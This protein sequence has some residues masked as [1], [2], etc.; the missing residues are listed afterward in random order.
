MN[1]SLCNLPYSGDNPVVFM[2]LKIHKEVIGR[3]FIRLFRDIFPAGVENFVRIAEGRSY[4]TE[5]KGVG[6]YKYIKEVRRTYEGAKFFNNLFN[7]Y[8][9]S[10]DIYS[11][12]GTNAGT[13]Y[14][15]HPIPP[16]YKD[17]YYPHEVKGMVSLVPFR[18]ETA[19]GCNRL[20]YDST[21]MILLNDIKPFNADVYHNL[22]KDQIV[23]GHVY[24]GTELLDKIN[25]LLQPFAGR[26][27]PDIRVGKCGIF[28]KTQPF[29]RTRPITL[30]DRKKMTVPCVNRVC[31]EACYK[32]SGQEAE[33]LGERC[34]PCEK[35][36]IDV[37]KCKELIKEA[38]RRQ[39]ELGAS[40]EIYAPDSREEFCPSQNCHEY[41]HPVNPNV[42]HE[43][44]NYVTTF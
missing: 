17:F 42:A 7:N 22:D 26:R 44:P 14:C 15:D 6:R 41:H 40:V 25:K 31:E 9:V 36:C 33:W 1:Y 2:D 3:I 24:A 28:K 43:D 20:F 16:Y 29:R 27:Y 34:D 35:G 18:D 21:F 12:D 8:I 38:E 32:Q 5:K 19:E 23:I 4:K 13:I 11:N 30:A 37:C 39:C 10:G